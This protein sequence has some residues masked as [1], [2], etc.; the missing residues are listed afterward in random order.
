MKKLGLLV[1]GVVFCGRLFGATLYVD[2]NSSAP[3]APFDS[4]ASASTNIQHAV[5]AAAAGDTILVTNGNYLLDAEILV[6]KQI[7]IQ[8]FNGPETTIVDGQGS[9][10]CFKFGRLRL[11]AQ[12]ADDYEWLCGK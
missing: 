7:T 4:W 2:L 6:T 12:W 11:H 8:S 3:A 9:V 10:R 1:L 5:D